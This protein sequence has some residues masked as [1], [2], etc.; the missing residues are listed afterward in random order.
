MA[1]TIKGINVVIGSD[2][3]GLSKALGD[4]NK[5]S[6]DI[7]SELKQVERLL[8]LD[9]SNTELLAQKQKLLGDAVSTTSD[10]LAQLKSVQEQVNQQFARGE[11][12][13]GQYRAFQ[14]EIAQTE[15]NLRGLEAQ[16]KSTEPA[17]KSLG[18]KMQAAGEKFSAAGQKMTDAGKSMSMKIT[19]P[20]VALGAGILKTG[21]D[22][23]AAMSK[24]QAISGST[25]DEMAAMTAQA[26]ELGAT[27][28][29]SASQAAS[30]MEFLARAGW[31]AQAVMA[32][33]PGM[34]NLAASGALELGEAADIT[35]NIMSAFSIE[36]S[37]A[38]RVADILA[39]ANSNANTNVQQLGQA[40]TYLAPT[41]A[42]MGQAI[43]QAT[44]AVMIMS[45]AGIQGEKAGAAFST[46]LQR[47][48][49]PTKAMRDVMDK[50]S[51]SFFDASGNMK[52]LTQIVS[53]LET[54]MAGYTKEQKAAAL[55]TMFGAE[56]YKNW[57]VLVETGS[58]A[59][60]RNVEMLENADGAAER[61]AKTMTDNAKGGLIQLM[62]AVEGLAI[63]L[64]EIL[65]PIFN[66]V[67][68]FLQNVVAW[69]ASMDEGTQKTILTIVGLVAAIGPLLIVLGT[70]AK[71]IGALMPVLAAL[72]SPIGLVI[73]AIAAMTAGLAILYNKNEAFR[74]FVD[75]TWA[76]IKDMFLKV[77]NEI[78]AFVKPILDD[79]SSFF[80][81]IF[82]NLL[83][84]W[85]THGEL[86]LSFIKPWLTGIVGF[87]K[88]QFEA[89]KTVI[90]VAWT[91][92]KAIIKI[93]IEGIKLTISTVLDLIM[94]IIRTFLKLLKGDWSGAFDEIMNTA[95]S[96]MDNILTFF[97]SID[98]LQVGKDMLQGLI[99]GIKSMS[100]KAV[101]TVKG[102]ANSLVSG[103]KGALGIN[104]P[105]KV[106][107][108]LGEW[109]GEGLVRGLQSTVA[110][111]SEQ[112]KALSQ[113]AIPDLK[114]PD[115]GL[116]SSAGG[117]VAAINLEGLFAG[118]TIVMRSD[119]DIRALARE[120]F[121]LQQQALRG[122]G[123]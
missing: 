100:G 92:I 16:L 46:S 66:D 19:A 3:T 78:V 97:K 72:T 2:T 24:V 84:F 57:A 121:A 122:A 90:D 87:F 74:K 109:S 15:Q 118:A 99:N 37:Q 39:V 75:E 33:M 44:A 82:N 22:F 77:W 52:P 51:I 20:V 8:K 107:M 102:V 68:G 10:K 63:Q 69:F 13:E 4:V 17:V 85:Q 35:S 120:I 73:A 5:R 76:A 53:E 55:S 108:E 67:I 21:I 6:R 9:P 1:E 104:S 62:S 32:A 12:S 86:I 27:T 38:G 64:S 58:E 96:I 79:L 42:T 47:L 83:E 29:F 30:G 70:I 26:K 56:A 105:S 59:L 116:G 71:S 112:A 18:E 88:I 11:I 81:G 40:M 103:I 65:L 7:Q 95:K 115:E 25:G 106:L 111:V 54:S 89:I 50:L 91:A 43:E 119:N 93:A 14:R 41:A 28:V 117:R 23:E 48:A 34:L 123:G 94:G 101:E 98:L 49:N 113:A 80:Q 31:D 114:Q 45:D 60:A 61:M 110:A 36:A